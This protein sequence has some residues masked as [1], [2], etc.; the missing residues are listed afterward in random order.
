MTG[1]IIKICDNKRDKYYDCTPYQIP[2]TLKLA[3]SIFDD[4]I[5]YGGYSSSFQH[6]L[7]TNKYPRILIATGAG[8]SYII[9]FI[10]YLKLN[11]NLLINDIFIHY[12]CRKIRLF[13]FVTDILAKINNNK[14]HVNAHLTSHKNISYNNNDNIQYRRDAA[15]GRATFER[16]LLDAPKSLVFLFLYK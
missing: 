12:S 11:D 1:F 2:F 8:C 4:L 10:Q 5:V 3:H 9:D 15:I 6:L 7:Y 13:Q 16:V 14:V